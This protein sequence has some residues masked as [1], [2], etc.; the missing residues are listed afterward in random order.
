MQA[1]V[2]SAFRDK[3]H[4]ESVYSI[5][6][7]FDGTDERVKELASAGFVVPIEEKTEKKPKASRKSTTKK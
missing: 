7:V 2:I 1:K 3:H 6:D 4:P 5:G